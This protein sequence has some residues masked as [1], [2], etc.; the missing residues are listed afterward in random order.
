MQLV[1]TA[2]VK[3][4]ETLGF[5]FIDRAVTLFKDVN[6]VEMHKEILQIL[7]KACHIS[8]NVG[9]QRSGIECQGL[10]SLPKNFNHR[11][12]DMEAH[13]LHNGELEDDDKALDGK[14]IL[15]VTQPAII[16]IGR[17][18]GSDYC[19]KR[20]LKKAIVWMG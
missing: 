5:I 19:A 11:S 15:L 13:Q 6:N 10:L 12:K 2:E 14:P 8:K 16:A 20:V 4:C 1:D 18:D 3:S 17:S 7:A 9:T